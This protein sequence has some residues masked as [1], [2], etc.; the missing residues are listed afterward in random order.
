M[1]NIDG[2]TDVAFNSANKIFNKNQNK[3]LNPTNQTPQTPK[4]LIYAISAIAILGI[5]VFVYQKNKKKTP[6]KKNK[7]VV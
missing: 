6:V 5:A 3:T 2:F 4:T 7:K 1:N